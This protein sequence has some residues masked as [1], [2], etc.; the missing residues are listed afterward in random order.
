[1]NLTTVRLMKSVL[2]PADILSQPTILFSKKYPLSTATERLLWLYASSSPSTL[3]QS[4]TYQ[5]N[6]FHTH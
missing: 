2:A 5:N 4:Y 3:I 6:K 1:M